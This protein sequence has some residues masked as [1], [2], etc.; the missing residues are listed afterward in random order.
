MKIELS[1][2][3]KKTGLTLRTPNQLPKPSASVK[4]EHLRPLTKKCGQGTHPDTWFDKHPRRSEQPRGACN[5]VQSLP[6]NARP[7]LPP[8]SSRVGGALTPLYSSCSMCAATRHTATCAHS[9]CTG[10]RFFFP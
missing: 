1:R 9:E 4:H 10:C 6:P 7:I 2:R 8:N 3:K 5:N